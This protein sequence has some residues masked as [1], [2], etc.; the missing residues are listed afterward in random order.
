[1]LSKIKLINKT[2][3][4][5]IIISFFIS[6]NT[7]PIISEKLQNKTYFDINYDDERVLLLYEG[8][9]EGEIP[10]NGWKLDINNSNYSWFIGNYNKHTGNYS[11]QCTNDPNNLLQDEW[12][13]TPIIDIKNYSEIYLSFWWSISYYWAVSPYDNYNLN[14]QI[15]IDNGLTWTKIWEEDNLQ[16][17]ENWKWYNT[18]FGKPIDLSEY[19]EYEKITIAFQYLGQNGAQLNIDD[20]E[21]YAIDSINNINVDIGGPYEAFVGQNIYFEENVSG[22]VKPYFYKWNFGDGEK[23]I[24][25][26]AVHKYDQIGIY[27]VTL[28]ITD[29]T[30]KKSR[31]YTKV[32]IINMSKKPNLII[33][34]LSGQNC[35][36]AKIKNIG[37]IPATNISWEIK[38]MGG[39]LNNI[40]QKT[41]GN[42]SNI[43]C[44]CSINI[45]SD[46]LFYLGIAKIN[47]YTKAE[48][49]ISSIKKA[50]CLIIRNNI[51]IIKNKI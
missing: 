1:M 43:D 12:L 47:I 32:T 37:D 3:L 29:F 39:L 33:Y 31:D 10:P 23:S 14:I 4:I 46:P 45:E 38:I 26:K 28:N 2:F 24:R 25:K 51:F 7:Y 9:E 50:Y 6:T 22:G 30:G 36:E 13:I 48:N 8:F 44:N 27:S 18:T 16:K 20:I 21:I 17:F 35:I 49:S 41:D 15:S 42:C 5:I 34:N 11:G 40:I 19:I